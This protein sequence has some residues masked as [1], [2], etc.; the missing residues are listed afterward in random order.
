MPIGAVAL[1]GVALFGG[2]KF[3]SYKANQREERREREVLAAPT[4]PP[5]TVPYDFGA[6]KKPQ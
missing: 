2:F 5:A 6:G 3:A 4:E 1:I